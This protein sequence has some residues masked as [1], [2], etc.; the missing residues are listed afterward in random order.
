MNNSSAIQ[1]VAVIGAGVMGEG[2]ALVF[3]QHGMQVRMMARHQETVDKCQSHIKA[4]LNMLQEYHLLDEPPTAIAARVTSTTNL[5]EAIDGADFIVETIAED[6]EA[7]KQLYAVLDKLPARVIIGSNT[8]SIPITQLSEDMQTPQRVIGTHF[9]NPPHIMPL[10][11]MHRGQ[12]TSDEVFE[13]TRQLMLSVGK[14]PVL[15]RKPIPGFAINRI[16]GAMMREI[17]YLLEEGVISPEDLDTAMKSSTGFK[18]AWLGPLALEDM[19]GL[20]IALRVHTR[21][22]QTL[23]SSATP[24]KLLVEKVQNNELGLKTGKGWLD[25]GGK[26]REEILE[27]TNRMLLQQLAIYNGRENAKDS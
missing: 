6:I 4:N 10:I 19:A 11:E 15:I 24:S 3:A 18:M 27:K 7:K 16:T 12:N 25:Y 8:S 17:C 5:H 22:Y 14:K 2:I 13:T 26:T 9:F 1:T 20:D 21:T 23:N